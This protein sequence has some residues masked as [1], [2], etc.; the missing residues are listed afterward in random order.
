MNFTFKRHICTASDPWS[1]E[2][3]VRAEHPDAVEIGDQVNGW[4][5][6]DLQKYRCP[7][8]GHTWTEE[9]PQ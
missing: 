5:G 2:K 6:G 4:P 1:P 7:H 3:C 9:L 8:C